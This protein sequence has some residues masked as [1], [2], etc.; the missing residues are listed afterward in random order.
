M[1]AEEKGIENIV[2]VRRE[3]GV[4]ASARLRDAPFET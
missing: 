1:S 3:Q 4:K 2:R